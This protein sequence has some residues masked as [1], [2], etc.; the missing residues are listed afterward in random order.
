ML[1][2]SDVISMYPASPDKYRAFSVSVVEW[3]GHP[4]NDGDI[5]SFVSWAVG[6]AH[7]MGLRYV[8]GVGMV[9]E[10]ALFMQTC[11]EWEQAICLNVRGERIRVPWLWDHSYNGNPAYWFCTN[12]PRYRSFLRDNVLLAVRAGVDGIHIDDHLGSSN[13]YWLDGCFCE[14]CVAG[15][16]DYLR[17]N[18]P[19]E[20][21]AELGIADLAA[22]DYRD[23][24]LT[25]LAAN[26]AQKAFDAPLGADYLVYQFRAARD[27]MA[28]L[29]ATAETQA[30]RPL[31]FSANG[32]PPSPSQMTD[33][34]VLTHFC[35]EVGHDTS[36]GANPAYTYKLS[37]ALDRAMVATAGGWDWA[38]VKANNRP[39]LVRAWIAQSYAF[40]QHFM[41]PHHQWC[42]TDELGTHWYDGPPEE[43]GPT[44]EFIRQH[45]PLFDGQE[46]IAQVGVVYSAKAA[47]QGETGDRQ[48]TE[49]L[50]RANI[51]FDMA[52]AGDEWV[53]ARLTMDHVR[54][55]AKVI[56]PA[57]LGLDAEQQQVID[58]LQAEGKL[59]TWAG[60]G[61]LA[62]LPPSWLTVGG[63]DYVWALPR[64]A[65]DGASAVIHLLNRDY[66]ASSDS[67]RPKGPFT[68]S[69]SAEAFGG[70][71]YAR[72]VLY[73]PGVEPRVLEL[74]SADARISFEVPSLSAWAV[75]H[76]TGE[77][78]RDVLADCWAY[79][80]IM[81]CRDAGI[82]VGFPDG[83]Y[84]PTWPVS[85]AE[86]AVYVSRACAGGAERV[87]TGP[88]T[89]RFPD[90]PTEHWAFD[91][92]EYAAEQGIVFGY[93][94]GDYRP[95][96][97]VDRGQMA[98]FIARA[99]A[100]PTGEAGMVGYTPPAVPT[101]PDV[102]PEDSWAWCYKHVE[103]IVERG[104]ARG[105]DDGTYRPAQTCTRDQMAVYVTRA[106]QL[107]T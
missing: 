65:T 106:F 18:V 38:F 14:N 93:P 74:S 62:Q 2:H 60:E 94:E 5:D 66:D 15:F 103:Y 8:G 88:A 34:D 64:Q 31:T 107:R 86:M 11:P 78:F 33:F 48:A 51:P 87:P 26:P 79:F 56:V 46:S 104:V 97:P 32:G 96:L 7:D 10:F 24:V 95:T 25:W 52:V 20:R 77:G 61:T 42:Y 21:L 44:Y 89:P 19:P 92:V 102:T 1:S 49:A 69:V 73:A 58:A 13:T 101:F 91:C 4:Q 59:V 76:L 71:A 100:T 37:A 57:T 35:A 16:R 85:R 17:D 40:G 50:L 72:A 67:V 6:P 9:T 55:F 43:Y 54:R 41:A 29:R 98:V 80:E 90:V 3:G 27:V 22:F 12:D 23:F 28:E 70:R 39:G 75:V 53:P 36:L 84:R 82:V 63:A 30:G 45:R 68:V 47:R 81:A 83:T 99:I 105:Y